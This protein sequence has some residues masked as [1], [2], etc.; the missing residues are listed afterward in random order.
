MFV[1]GSQLGLMHQIH[2]MRGPLELGL[3]IRLATFLSSQVNL[4]IERG[5]VLIGIKQ[6]ITRRDPHLPQATITGMPD[7][8]CAVRHPFT[9]PPTI[10]QHSACPAP[11][12]TRG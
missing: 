2:S 7:H 1:M 12:L 3:D 6:E 9:A 10:P 4:Y 8:K 11:L 5:V